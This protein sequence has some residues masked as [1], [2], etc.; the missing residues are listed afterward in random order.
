MAIVFLE[1]FD[2]Y[3]IGNSQACAPAGVLERKYAVV[4]APGNITSEPGRFGGYVVYFRSDASVLKTK[5]LTTSDTL[6]AGV[7]FNTGGYYGAET[8]L[9]SFYDGDTLGVSV[10][11]APTAT[12]QLKV[13]SGGTL[14]ST[15]SGTCLGTTTD[16]ACSSSTWYHIELKVLC[17]EEGTWELRVNGVTKLSGT[18]NT[19]LGI[20]DYHDACQ[21]AIAY[22]VPVQFDDWYVCDGS[23]GINDDFR[24]VCRVQTIWPGS[25][26]A[27]AGWTP[28][29]G[30]HFAC[31]SENPAND[32]TSYVAGENGDT[33]LYGFVDLSGVGGTIYGLQI[34]SQVRQT[35]AT[36]ES[37]HLTVGAY[38]GPALS[39]GTQSYI[40]VAHC[41]DFNP[42]TSSA[43]TLTTVNDTQF[44]LK[45]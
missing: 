16:C 30:S 1:G 17:A 13:Y 23:S 3:G 21:L 28:S 43:W 29:S 22:G 45:V 20:H 27:E 4:G 33:D 36:L 12:P 2:T 5:P 24:G 9:L 41:L 10:R 31:V 39:V 14:W 34:S 7:S 35:D 26:T 42:A 40:F 37:L 18:T 32:D 44:G 19:K 8:F 25:D 38:D 11:L 15:G 6:I